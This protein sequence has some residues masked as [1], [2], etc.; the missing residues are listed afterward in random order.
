[1]PRTRSLAWSELKI[2]I[3]AVVALVAGER[4]DL[5]ARRRRRASSGSAT[6]SR[7][8]STTSPGSRRARRCA[9]PASRSARSSDVELRRRPGRSRRWR[10][11]RSTAAADHDRVARD[12]RARC[13]CSARRAVDITPSS[14]G[15]PIPEWGYV[16]TG[17]PPASIAEVG[18]AGDRGH[19][20]GDGAAAGH[21]RRPRHGG[22]A[23]HRRCGLPRLDALVQSA[24]RVASQIASGRGTLGRLTNDPTR[25]TTRW[26]PR[27][28]TSMRSRRA[29][30]AA[31]A[32][33]G[34][35]STIRRWPTR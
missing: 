35:S 25:C 19:R 7:P 9:S 24:E 3:V 6:R 11:R 12:A 30:A 4:A 2:G 17:R 14:E 10:S 31:R 33:S 32:A 22:Q 15:T 26:R 8:S 28:A 23:L 34:S 27:S 13:R 5:P 29:F 1:M 21:P 20:G 16:P 18:D